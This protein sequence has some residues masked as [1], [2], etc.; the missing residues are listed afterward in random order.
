MQIPIID[1]DIGKQQKKK[2]NLFYSDIK[3][4]LSHLGRVLGMVPEL[5]FRT[6]KALTCYYTVLWWSSSVR[7]VK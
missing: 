2:K 1:G 3:S 6:S 7:T 5:A 4:G